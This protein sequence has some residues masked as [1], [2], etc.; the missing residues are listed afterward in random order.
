[1]KK[2]VEGL[3]NI[4]GE[5]PGADDSD[6]DLDRLHRGRGRPMEAEGGIEIT[7]VRPIIPDEILAK[8]IFWSEH[9]QAKGEAQETPP[10][11]RLDWRELS[12]HRVEPTRDPAITGAVI[13]P[14]R[15]PDQLHA[16]RIASVGEGEDIILYEQA[17]GS[18]GFLVR[19]PGGTSQE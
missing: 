1:M 2:P 8:D 10:V 11:W 18:D 4:P 17:E 3:L 15:Y 13:Q 9:A 19:S 7:G 16:V 5:R 14:G 6:I 12:A